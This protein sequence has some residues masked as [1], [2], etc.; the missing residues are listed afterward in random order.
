MPDRLPEH[1]KRFFAAVKTGEKRKLR[2]REKRK[3]PIWFGLGTF[4]M[5]GWAVAI[6]TV[7]G[8]FL[9]VWIDLRWPG[10]YSWTLMLLVIGLVLGCINAWFWINRQRRTIE[11]ERN[12]HG[13]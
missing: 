8:I 12:D 7:L 10:P 2:A 3:D 9:G 1:D 5:V 13:R 6:P 11:R 4:G